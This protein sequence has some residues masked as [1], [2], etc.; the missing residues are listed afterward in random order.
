MSK[1]IFIV[2]PTASEKTEVSFSLARRLNCEIISCD[3]MLIYKE[4]RI[5]TSKPYS[6]IRKKIKHHF[7]DIIS[8]KDAY[9]VFD[10]YKKA[11]KRIIALFNK[12]KSVIVCGGSGLYVKALCDGLFD[13][14]PK[15][16]NLRKD[17]ARKAK[18]KGNQSL[19]KELESVDEKTAAKLSP[20][21]LRRIIRAL[22]VYYL[23]G[24][25]I[26]EKKAQ[27]R[28]L[29]T[30]YPIKMFAFSYRRD[31]LYGRINK[32]T[33]EMFAEGVIDEVRRLRKIGLS[34]TA[35]K[36]IGIKEISEY[37][38]NKVGK[39]LAKENMKRNTRRFAKRQLTWFKADKRIEWI[40]AESL[41]ADNLKDE[42]L[43][44]I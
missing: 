34:F 4:P 23:T 42:I 44:K 7:I 13:D 25:P 22:E 21:D 20:N 12:G 18:T 2:G 14:P 31:T 39:S 24:V 17:L 33:E 19:H 3:S 9:S 5:I 40:G 26:S 8:V 41:S 43:K 32:R 11:T 10:Y 16:E 28:G 36:I 37:L 30:R 35:E 1:I 29:Y 15:D 27:T 6:Y 38:D